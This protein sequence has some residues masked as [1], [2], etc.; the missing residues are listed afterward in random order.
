MDTNVDITQRGM[1]C[2]ECKSALVHKYGH[3]RKRL[4]GTKTVITVQKYRC[5]NCLRQFIPK[6]NLTGIS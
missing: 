1:I 2:P 3:W 5:Y 4:T 6:G